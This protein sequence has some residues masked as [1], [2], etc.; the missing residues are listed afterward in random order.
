MGR[1]TLQGIWKSVD[2]YDPEIDKR[3]LETNENQVCANH[4]AIIGLTISANDGCANEGKYLQHIG[5]EVLFYNDY[6]SSKFR[7]FS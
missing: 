7:K 4:L 5:P 1:A 3:R 6:A 2:A